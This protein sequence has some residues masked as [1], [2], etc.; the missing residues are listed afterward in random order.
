[1]IKIIFLFLSLPLSFAFL[2]DHEKGTE[3]KDYTFVYSMKNH[4]KKGGNK[5]FRRIF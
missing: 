3:K 4:N 2:Q 5:A 1:M